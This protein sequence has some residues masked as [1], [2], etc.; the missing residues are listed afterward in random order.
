MNR[1]SIRHLAQH[2]VGTR[3]S[4]GAV[5]LGGLLAVAAATGI[6]LSQID[7]SQPSRASSAVAP[8]VAS[9]APEAPATPSPAEKVL[10][11]QF[12]Q[13]PNFYWC[14]P[15]AA[16]NALAAGG[17]AVTQ[18]DMAS[19]LRTTTSGTDSAFDVTRGLNE[20]VGADVYQTREIRGQVATP[21]ETGQLQ[22]DV[23]RAVTDGRAVVANIVTSAWDTNGISHS[24][25]GG[26][27]VAIVGYKDGGRIVKVADSANPNGDG[28]YWMTT[29]NMATWI[30][31]RG[32]SF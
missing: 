8:V 16:R 3:R 17:Y 15:A 12:Q 29:D 18:A 20:I 21:A 7:G 11:A 27:Y 2:A 26:H 4:R 6:V 32:Y 24:F 19:K 9:A 14:G 5:L 22:T 1:A 25:D 13:Q 28:T 31:R 23:V 30:A 10:E